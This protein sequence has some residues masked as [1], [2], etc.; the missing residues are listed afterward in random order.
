MST[1]S[2]PTNGSF[3]GKKRNVRREDGADIKATSV[4]ESVSFVDV[5]VDEGVC[6]LYFP[7]APPLEAPWREI[8]SALHSLY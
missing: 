8:H 3:A 1:Q 5:G 2:R 4:Y 7:T 6:G